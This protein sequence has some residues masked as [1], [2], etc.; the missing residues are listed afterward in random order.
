MEDTRP[1]ARPRAWP[2]VLMSGAH[3][4]A[5]GPPPEYGSC[6]ELQIAGRVRP[7][8]AQA[9][10]SGRL[11]APAEYVDRPSVLGGAADR[12]VAPREHRLTAAQQGMAAQL[13]ERLDACARH[14]GSAVEG[15]D[16]D[17]L[18]QL[19]CGWLRELGAA[20]L[21]PVFRFI[22]NVDRTRQGQPV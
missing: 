8:L 5:A 17:L 14:A 20:D 6:A 3:A 1:H 18:L 11:R 15:E 12:F 10:R 13:L 21:Q 16:P 22:I 9:A 4:I 2:H 7:L 19:I